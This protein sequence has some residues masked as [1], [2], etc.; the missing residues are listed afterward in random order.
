L[1]GK[2]AE[3][4]AG[5]LLDIHVILDVLLAR[6]PYVEAAV[7]IL[8]LAERGEVRGHVCAASVD[9][10]DYILRKSLGAKTARTHLRTLC[11]VLRVVAVDAEVIDDALSSEWSDFED[12]VAHACAVRAG[13]DAIVTRNS[14]DFVSASLPVFSP[15]EFLAAWEGH[16]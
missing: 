7:R 14:K 10:L 11:R 13:L 15:E 4:V 6:P 3:R 2:Q 9:T 12:A 5:V 16:R 8:A 1:K